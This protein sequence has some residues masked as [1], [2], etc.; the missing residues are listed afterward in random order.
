MIL[1]M[2]AGKIGSMPTFGIDIDA[3]AIPTTLSN[4][5]HLGALRWNTTRCQ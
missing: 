2:S 4:S 3:S 5:Y 1:I